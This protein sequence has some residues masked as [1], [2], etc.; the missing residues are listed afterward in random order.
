MRY[1]IEGK[2]IFLDSWIREEFTITGIF[3][4]MNICVYVPNGIVYKYT[5]FSWA[6]Y[7]CS[8]QSSHNL[9]SAYGRRGARHTFSSENLG[10]FRPTFPT[11]K[12]LK[13]HLWGLKG[14]VIW[15][16]MVTEL[17]Q[18]FKLETAKSKQER[19]KIAQF[20]NSRSSYSSLVIM[21]S[22]HA[23][24]PLNNVI[25]KDN[26]D[27]KIEHYDYQKHE[28]VFKSLSIKVYL[29]LTISSIISRFSCILIQWI[30]IV[31]MKLH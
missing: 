25:H 22:N 2:S 9:S 27:T 28:V 6:R 16:L 1:K 18:K 3:V 4:H 13:A 15:V 21:K 24:W 23:L 7:S 26:Q 19:W 10:R 12:I 20:S 14:V 29:Y 8:C 5:V 17:I 31:G 11:C 30:V